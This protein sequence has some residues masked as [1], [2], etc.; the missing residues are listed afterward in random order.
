MNRQFE[1][2]T[3]AA[4][5]IAI[6]RHR[7]PKL[8]RS[9]KVL[10]QTAAGVFLD[11]PQPTVRRWL[12]GAVPDHENV[13]TLARRLELTVAQVRGEQPIAGIDFEESSGPPLSADGNI[14]IYRRVPLIT[15][16]MA[17]EIK[18]TTDLYT[19]AVKEWQATTARVGDRAFAMR[20][21]GKSMQNPNGYPSLEDG[22]IVIVD[23]D[24]TETNGKI[25]VAKI[26]GS[27]EITIKK[28]VND[29]PHS[30][31][32]PLN[33]DYKPIKIDGNCQIIGVVRQVIQ[34]M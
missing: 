34:D 6:C 27:P 3:F 16:A 19:P 22:S 17:A 24:A 26:S 4:T 10:N 30:Y 2:R 11:F 7:R 33:P 31:L 18:D 20:V 21:E 1:P 14:A 28:L 8:M 12:N 32:V 13:E 23:P 5:L 25:V 9:D 29:G 15:A